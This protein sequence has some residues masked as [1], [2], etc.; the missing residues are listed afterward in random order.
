MNTLNTINP[1]YH[2]PHR[3]PVPAP[4]PAYP[5]THMPRR[6]L[7]TGDCGFVVYCADPLPPFVF[8]AAQSVRCQCRSYWPNPHT[9]D[10]CAC[11]HH[12]CYHSNTQQQSTTT[13]P[14]APTPAPPA[15]SS[16]SSVLTMGAVANL[17]KRISRLE[18]ELEAQRERELKRESQ[19]RSR[20]GPE[21]KEVVCGLRGIDEKVDELLERMDEAEERLSGTERIGVEFEGRLNELEV[22]A[23]EIEDD[24][25]G[26][27]RQDEEDEEDEE[28]ERLEKKETRRNMEIDAESESDSESET[29]RNAAVKVEPVTATSTG[30]RIAEKIAEK[31][32]DT[33]A[34]AAATTAAKG[35]A[36]TTACIILAQPPFNKTFSLKR[37]SSDSNLLLVE[38]SSHPAAKR[39]R[40]QSSGGS[41]SA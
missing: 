18:Q 30:G 19:S 9:P 15:P 35:A 24:V 16:P 37:R 12:A 28:R 31:I 25:T 3:A 17:M 8:N 34:A 38:H 6:M 39:I 21:M 26:L 29:G 20:S 14:P 22:R 1:H 23:D 5:I 40:C 13:V 10:L 2:M 36:I 33:K 32:V 11:G 4:F 7:P 27:V 41:I